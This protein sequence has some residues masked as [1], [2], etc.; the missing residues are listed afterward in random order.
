[1]WTRRG[2]G[3][4]INESVQVRVLAAEGD[5]VRLG[6]VAPREVPI[7]R[8]ELEATTGID[9]SGQ[10]FQEGV[11]LGKVAVS[12]GILSGWVARQ[13]N[14]YLK[15]RPRGTL[16]RLAETV[17]VSLAS[18]NRWRNQKTNVATEHLHTLLEA[19]GV[20]LDDLA[21]ELG[22]REVVPPEI[23]ARGP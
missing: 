2:S 13:L 1:V 19:L 8:Q 7:H 12:S 6:I 17:G 4:L 9:S 11:S 3:V 15:D 23:R 21:K 18:I 10:G 5:Y 14:S 22:V 20:S 16:Q